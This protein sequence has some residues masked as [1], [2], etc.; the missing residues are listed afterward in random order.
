MPHRVVDKIEAD[1]LANGGFQQMLTNHVVR[2]LHWAQGHL[3]TQSP[4]GSAQ[5]EH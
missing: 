5:H 3:V 1:V 4:L 2:C